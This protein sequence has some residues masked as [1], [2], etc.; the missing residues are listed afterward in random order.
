MYVSL[1]TNC[2][3][4]KVQHLHVQIVCITCL[5][6]YCVITRIPSRTNHEIDKVQH[7]HVQT[8]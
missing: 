7:F 6:D 3:R 5:L 8:V 1:R 4:D 2:K